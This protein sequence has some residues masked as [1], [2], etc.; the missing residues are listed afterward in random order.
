MWF[1]WLPITGSLPRFFISVDS[2]WIRISVSPLETALAGDCLSVD[3][4]RLVCA[5]IA[6]RYGFFHSVENE[7]TWAAAQSTRK[8]D[9][10]KVL[11][12]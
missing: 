7:E 1:V 4:K 11:A 2:K 12:L 3:S 6:E 10:S 5:K 8:K 9:A